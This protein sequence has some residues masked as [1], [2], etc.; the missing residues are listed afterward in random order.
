MQPILELIDQWNAEAS[1]CESQIKAAT[2][3]AGIVAL[4]SRAAWSR[5]HANELEIALLAIRRQQAEE[6]MILLQAG[7][8]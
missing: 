3:L 7:R 1:V 8:N 6:R 4:K 2:C 5:L